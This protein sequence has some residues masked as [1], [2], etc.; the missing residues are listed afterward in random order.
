VDV[1]VEKERLTQDLARR[2]GARR[3]RGWAT[4]ELDRAEREVV[5]A[6]GWPAAEAAANDIP[7]GA[8]TRVARSP[9]GRDMIVL[10][11]PS[12]EGRLAAS[13]ARHGE[14]FL[15]D[16][17]LVNEGLDEAVELVRQEG[18]TLSSA[19]SGPFGPERLVASSPRWGPHVIVAA[20]D[21]ERP[22]PN[23]AAAATRANRHLAR[24]QLPSRRDRPDGYRPP[25]SDR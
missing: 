6:R 17:L 10:L 12:T 9:D 3:V 4:V 22:P 2:L 1:D 16:Y 15:V 14:G 18:L 7:L 8:F 13:L 23:R 20:R 21:R 5:E 19:T 25:R 11:E 24:E